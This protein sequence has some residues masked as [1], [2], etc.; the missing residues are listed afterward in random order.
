MYVLYSLRPRIST[1]I[2][3]VLSCTVDGV[4]NAVEWQ[5]KRYMRLYK[6]ESE[7]QIEEILPLSE[8]LAKIGDCYFYVSICCI[9][10]V[11][12]SSPLTAFYKGEEK[13]ALKA[14]YVSTS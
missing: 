13:K 4:L 9:L 7:V 14:P 2:S 11:Y 5:E 1:V 8:I 10:L 3:L 6:G 12:R